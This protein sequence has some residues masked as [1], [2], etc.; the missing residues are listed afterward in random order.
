MP[1]KSKAQVRKMFALEERGE[2]PQGKAEEMAHE[3][4]NIKK[5]PEKVKVKSHHQKGRYHE[6]R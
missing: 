2:L 6:H 3:T 4:P 1:L 5:L